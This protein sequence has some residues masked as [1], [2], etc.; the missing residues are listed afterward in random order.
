MRWNVVIGGQLFSKSFLGYTTYKMDSRRARAAARD[1]HHDPAVR[2]PRRPAAPPA[3]VAVGRRPSPAR[4]RESRP[5]AEPAAIAHEGAMPD[6]LSEIEARLERL[7]GV[8][9]D[10][11]LADAVPRAIGVAFGLRLPA[12]LLQARP[13]AIVWLTLAGRTL[14]VLGG[15]YL[16][17]A[18]TESG[19]LS[20]SA[21]VLIGLG[22]ALA[23]LG[24][25]TGP[26][27]AAIEN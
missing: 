4:R 24:A 2:H 8:V 20:A 11:R 13:D 14:M 1:P 12:G 23:W 25:P 10:L 17:R 18:I 7:E 9:R 6:R 26:V 3:A 21:G 16:L 5:V 22:Y 27:S 19:R 15:A